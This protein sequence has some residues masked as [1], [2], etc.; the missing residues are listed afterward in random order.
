MV[1]NPFFKIYSTIF[2]VSWIMHN[3]DNRVSVPS[4]SEARQLFAN[5]KSKYDT[6]LL[7]IHSDGTYEKLA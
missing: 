5:L 4:E 2:V 6:C 1:K 3:E 7:A